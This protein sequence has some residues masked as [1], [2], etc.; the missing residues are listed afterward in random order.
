MVGSGKGTKRADGGEVGVGSCE[1][2]EI[3]AFDCVNPGTV[4]LNCVVLNAG[5]E[6]AEGCDDEGGG[7]EFAGNTMLL[8]A[9][10]QI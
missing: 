3:D 9:A 6:D 4:E 8:I 2:F 10:A 5:A 7:E 1:I